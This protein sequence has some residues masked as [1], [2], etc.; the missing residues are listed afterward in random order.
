MS[1]TSGYNRLRSIVPKTFPST[2]VIRRA[3][4]SF[5]IVPGVINSIIEL[6]S[7]KLLKY[8][9][10]NQKIILSFDQFSVSDKVEYSQQHKISVGLPTLEPSYANA[11][12]QN[13]LIIIAQCLTLPIRIPVSVDFT[14]S[15]TKPGS[16]KFYK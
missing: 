1:G 15:S 4:L 11:E 2:R 6:F 7:N 9:L 13:C 14:T 12:V 10:Y 3:L 16:V 5:Y 8:P